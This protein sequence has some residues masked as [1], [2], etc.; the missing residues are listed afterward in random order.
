MPPEMIP[1]ALRGFP[2][3]STLALL[4]AVAATAG[5]LTRTPISLVA[6][7]GY[8]ISQLGYALIV[9]GIVTGKFG[10]LGLKGRMLLLPLCYQNEPK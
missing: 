3:W 4:Y 7:L 2:V 5:I 10:M 6:G 1:A 8:G 9:A